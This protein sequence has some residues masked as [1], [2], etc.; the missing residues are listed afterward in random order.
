MQS[1]YFIFLAISRPQQQGKDSV[2]E[3]TN[4][5]FF[6]LLLMYLL[7]FNRMD[8][9]AVFPESLYIYLILANS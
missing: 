2:I 6:T 3:L 7:Y 4:E 8:K 1:G 5:A 9:W